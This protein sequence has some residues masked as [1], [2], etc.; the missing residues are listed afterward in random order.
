MTGPSESFR[1]DRLELI[2]DIGKRPPVELSP[3]GM[4]DCLV[5]EYNG[6][7]NLTTGQLTLAPAV[8][9]PQ[10][11]LPVSESLTLISGSAVVAVEGREYVLCLLDNITI[12]KMLPHQILNRSAYEPARL[13]S[14]IALASPV[15]EPVST[16][17][18]T[19]LVPQ[20]S[21]GVP[22]KEHFS[23]F[24]TVP[25]SEAGPERASSITSIKISFQVLR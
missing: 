13:H 4:F 10:Y 22:G 15:R 24:K 6:A 23:R 7:R 17:F 8:R 3:G 14:A 20:T 21:S 19:H 9:L 18:S 5:G 16:N 25:R 11:S 12:P 1:P 2:S